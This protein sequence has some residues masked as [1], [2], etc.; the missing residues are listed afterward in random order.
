MSEK[1][2]LGLSRNRLFDFDNCV[3]FL[4]EAEVSFDIP[5]CEKTLKTLCLKEAILCCGVELC[6]NGEAYLVT[7]Q[8]EIVLETFQGDVEEFV[9]NKKHNG[10]DFTKELFSFV[11]LNGN[12]LGIFAHTVIADSRSLMYLAGE[13]M[14][15]YK[16][17][18]LS[19][20]PSE[21]KVLSE[22][23]QMPSNVF[24]VVIDRLAS[25]LEVGWQKK[26][27]VFTLED[28]KKA[29]DKYL[30]IKSLTGNISVEIAKE[31]L[32]NLKNF[33]HRECIDVSS[34]VAFAF[35]ESLTRILGGRRKYRKLNV[36]ANERI[37]FE[38]FGKMQV[39]SFNGFVP[40]EKKK[41][42]KPPDTLEN[43]AVNFHKEIYKRV[44]S[45]FK[46]FYNEFLFM[47]LP[48][49][50]VDSQYMYCAGE[51]EHKYSKKLANTYGCNNEVVGEFCSYNLNQSFW[52]TLDVFKN[53]VPCEPLKMR[54]STLITFVEKDGKGEVRFE[55]KKERLS[56]SDAQLVVKKAM[57]LLSKFN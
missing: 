26:T 9:K 3:C 45:A 15:L 30:K 6:G 27:S 48:P 39:G 57:D 35:Y 38:D 36:Q 32:V 17:K 54:S 10:L 43:N 31:L 1:I 34:L 8:N 56:D 24:S 52:S 12:T 14:K 11:V 42:K 41:D 18:T 40:V 2:K 25:D 28:Y 44:T 51:F 19:V 7:E 49:S 50:F 29:R 55:Y 23:S 16:S 4:G 13:F 21:I 47:R 33:A 37:F 22:I 53:V 5:E 46:V 20:T